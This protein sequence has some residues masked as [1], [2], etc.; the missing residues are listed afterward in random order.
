MRSGEAQTDMLKLLWNFVTSR[1]LAIVLLMIITFML[2]VG[3]ILPNPAFLSPEKKI[4]MKIRHPLLFTLGES[5]NSQKLA[6]GYF[7]GF[8]GIFL[9]IST[10]LCSIDRLMTKRKAV[11]DALF[12]LPIL[13]SKQGKQLVI[14]G[15]GTDHIAIIC[16]EWF[17]A[18]K[19]KISERMD[20][21]GLTIVGARGNAGFWGSIFFHFILIT[22]LIGLVIYYLG[23][24]RGTLGFTE[25][26]SY[27]LDRSS[28]VHIVK[29]PIWGLRLPEVR[30]GL[31]KQY[32][33]YPESDPWNAIDHVA[34]FEIT[35]LR[36]GRTT[37]ETVRI[38][39]PLEIHGM[40]FLMQVGGFSPRI[41]I[42]D[43]NG[44]TIF[45]NF[46]ALR[47]K[48]G[49]SDSFNIPA[50]GAT[51]EATIYPDFYYKEGKADTKSYQAKNPFL[52]VKIERN[53][54][55]LF[56]GLTPFNSEAK[57]GEFTLRFPEVRR[58]V[59]MELV[60][61]PGI[62]FF[63]LIS[64]IGLIGIFVRII[65]PDERIY[66]ILKGY[67]NRSELTAY[68]YSKHFSG[69]IE[70]KMNDLLNHIGEKCS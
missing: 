49:T 25:G 24:Y 3:A 13:T 45:N 68:T 2:A 64:F 32:S 7:F 33:I 1:N 41:E 22:A 21:N 69:M 56:S 58:W 54:E 23:G 28:F 67:D 20:E 35:D 50:I 47:Q 10:S 57:S 65:D 60:G 40:E 66:I 46:V 70:E 48:G 59:E 17:A 61:E 42:I 27:R 19:M 55:V 51:A 16:R 36:T 52:Q 9:I 44:I 34:I 53:G 5:Y 14:A 62:G 26:Q 39:D 4:E 43:S 29:E 15:H 11:R 30:I 6:N 31:K 8:V 38:N 63:F 37:E 18:R 12:S